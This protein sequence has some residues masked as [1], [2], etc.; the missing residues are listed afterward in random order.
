MYAENKAFLDQYK[1]D[2]N[3]TYGIDLSD[4]EMLEIAFIYDMVASVNN[5]LAYFYSSEDISNYN[6]SEKSSYKD[7]YSAYLS[8]LNIDFATILYLKK[9]PKYLCK[10]VL[11]Q[12][13][14]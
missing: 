3:N 9:I 4:N 11:K 10:D 13:K 6:L 14:E 12:L 7:Y 1:Q 5:G 2:Y 8:A